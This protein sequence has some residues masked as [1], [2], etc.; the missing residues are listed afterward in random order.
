MSDTP[1]CNANESVTCK[2]GD[3]CIAPDF[4]RQLERENK[5]LRQALSG[6]TV[7]CSNCNESATQLR[8]AEAE[9]SVSN[10]ERDGYRRENAAMSEAIKAI[11]FDTEG[12]ADGAPDAS[13]HDKLCNEI[14][15]KL[16][17]YLK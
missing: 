1:R 5:E 14:S 12:Y 8:T 7:S 11:Y 13:R 17:P 6:R 10:D 4:A 9:L 2:E 16:Q 3:L 15:S